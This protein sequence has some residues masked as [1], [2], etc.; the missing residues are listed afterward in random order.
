MEIRPRLERYLRKYWILFRIK[1]M[2]IYIFPTTLGFASAAAEGGRT[3]GYKIALMYL[4]F[5]CGS[6]FSSSLN[7]YADVE[8]DRLH[9]DMY[10][11]DLHMSDQPFATGEMGKLETA[12][13]FTLSG[14]GCVLFSL[15]V[16]A[17]YALFM[18]G[19]VVILGI[20]YS[21][22]WFRLK[23]KP[24]LDIATNALG[25]VV[26]LVAGW[27]ALLPASWPGFWPLSYGFL[28]SATLYIPSVANDVPFDEAAGFRTS[29]VVFG[30]D[31]MLKAMIPM[32]LLLIPVTVYNFT[33]PIAW[34]FKLFF[35]LSL[36]GAIVFTVGMHLLWK[37][38]HIRFNAG[39]LVYPIAA[40]LLFYFVYGV[41]AALG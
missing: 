21:H 12:L 15:L 33:L 27:N 26:L 14:A 8:S 29:G 1:T 11:G 39:L 4:G 18:V 41:N 9:N 16:N 7:F 30:A 23:A 22:P 19:S 28:F 6:F 13:L 17:W 40:L 34:T 37:P 3:S 20:L 10:K 25:A 2:F 31:A 5:L 38:P 32:C 24:V 35:A 36:P